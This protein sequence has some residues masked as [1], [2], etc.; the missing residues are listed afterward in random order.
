MSDTTTLSIESILCFC[1]TD[2]TGF[3]EQR[4]IEAAASDFVSGNQSIGGD[5]HLCHSQ[6]P[7]LFPH[8]VLS[9]HQQ[10][11]LHTLWFLGDASPK[12]G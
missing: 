11:R 9:W 10:G 8:L 7:T 2:S 5:P 12:P 3:A 4:Y 1:S 6:Q